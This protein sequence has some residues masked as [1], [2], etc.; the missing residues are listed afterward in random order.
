MDA[1]ILL[2]F[3]GAL[4]V[5]AQAQQV[6]KCVTGKSVSYQSA[7]CVSGSAVKSWD[8]TPQPEPSNA[9]IS[10]RYRLQ[11]EMDR[12]YAAQHSAS[13]GYGSNVSSSQSS[14]ACEA[15]KRQRDAVY[16]AAGIHRSFEVSSKMDN[17]VHDAC[18]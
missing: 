5:P 1:R 9:E 16:A 6:Y 2:V 7:P 14:N 18:R 15:A 11:Q 13:S 17:L 4:A 10:R 8:A 3:L 12:R